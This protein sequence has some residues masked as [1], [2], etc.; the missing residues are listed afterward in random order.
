MGDGITRSK[1][2][3]PQWDGDSRSFQEY[4]EMSL[5]WEQGIPTHK[6]Y[7]CG[8][9][10]MQDKGLHPQGQDDDFHDASEGGFDPWKLWSESW[11]TAT[12]YQEDEQWTQSTTELLPDYL[13]GW[14]LLH[15]A[16]LDSHEKNMIQT[17]VG[18]TFS[19]TRISQELRAQ[20][21]KDELMKRDQAHKHSSFWNQDDISEGESSM[22]EPQTTAEETGMA[23]LQQARRSLKE[24]RAKQHQ[25]KMSRQYYKITT[26]DKSRP[27]GDSAGKGCMKCFR[28]GGPH[29][30]ANCPDR[31]EPSRHE[32]GHVAQEEAP[33]VCYA[34]AATEAVTLFADDAYLAETGATKSRKSTEQAIAE[35]YG[36]VDGGA[37]K[38]LGSVYAMEALV[39]ANLRKHQDGGVLEVDVNNQP[40]LGLSNSSRNKCLSTAKI[41]AGGKEGP[42]TC[43]GTG[44]IRALGEEPPTKWT[45]SELRVRLQELE[46]EKG[47]VRAHGKKEKNE[48]LLPEIQYV[49]KKGMTSTSD[50]GISKVTSGYPSKPK[51]DVEALKEERPHKKKE[52]S[53][54]DFTM[55]SEMVSEATEA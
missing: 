35:G 43:S 38:T 30:I 11:Y 29:K 21:P 39:N 46:E 25:V 34:E 2:G 15:D 26:S 7:L 31:A 47:I 44:A 17:A 51:E 36:I 45:N 4:E 23:A 9:R 12:P 1:D 55:V 52:K 16:G 50:K 27:A 49:K 13:Q 22:Q 28:R 19:T 5:Q 3:V 32:Q 40:V 54:D 14:Y 42:D 10:L 33:F 53:E 8:P 18:N 20:W 48:E 41:C 6:R 24:A 37:T